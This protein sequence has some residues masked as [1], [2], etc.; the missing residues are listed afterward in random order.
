MYFL[1]MK[2]RIIGFN[3]YADEIPLIQQAQALYQLKFQ[4]HIIIWIPNNGQNPT[5][6]LVKKRK[7]GARVKEL[8]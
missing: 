6:T 3:N 7:G 5:H 8:I 2:F 4:I 1:N